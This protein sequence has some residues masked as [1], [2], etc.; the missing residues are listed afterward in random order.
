MLGEAQA[1]HTAGH[2]DDAYRLEE[3]IATAQRGDDEYALFHSH[4]GLA[5]LHYLQQNYT[6]AAARMERAVES[7]S[8][9]KNL[10]AHGVA[11]A[12]EM[13]RLAKNAEGVTKHARLA[14]SAFTGDRA[15]YPRLFFNVAVALR[16]IQ[17]YDE[18]LN[19]YK[20]FVDKSE[21]RLDALQNMAPVHALKGDLR[22][23]ASAMLEYLAS[24]QTDH[25][26]RVILGV[27]LIKSGQMDSAMEHFL[28]VIDSPSAG[29]EMRI[30]AYVN[31]GA[32]HQKRGQ[33]EAA[34]RLYA[35]ALKLDPNNGGAHNNMGSSLW[36]LSDHT[37]AI[38][39]FKR[40]LDVKYH[41]VQAHINLGTSLYVLGDIVGARREYEIAGEQDAK[42]KAAMLLRSATLMSP[43]MKSG[44]YILAERKRVL[45]ELR[46]L[47]RSADEALVIDDPA[48]DIE[49][50][51]F[52]LLYHG[53]NELENQLA[54]R[55]VHAR[56]SHACYT[57][58][59]LTKSWMGRRRVQ[60][61]AAPM[62]VAFVSRSLH[63]NH[64]H[65]QLLQGVM[66][67]LSRRLFDVYAVSFG[68]A[69][70]AFSDDIVR[71]LPSDRRFVFSLDFTEA[72]LQLGR[73]EL[74]AIVYAD[75]MSEPTTHYMGYARLAPVQVAFWGNPVSSGAPHIDY[76][77]SGDIM[78]T[79]SAWTHY[80]NSCALLASGYGMTAACRRRCACPQQNHVTFMVPQSV[81]KFHPLTQQSPKLCNALRRVL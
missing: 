80:S 31:A 69:N 78:E 36:Q 76:F 49:R 39:H 28:R 9:S 75:T 52:Y 35:A 43:I 22:S 68:P 40:S 20:I 62:R 37:Q 23:A 30:R 21:T 32:I 4:R 45:E 48:T 47:S 15:S 3:V 56:M 63:E 64:A 13:M 53:K 66:A 16:D 57:A 44:A 26:A 29:E 60:I 54:V 41:N 7:V 65:G 58:P 34:V 70:G 73:L 38:E 10:L 33:F 27:Y 25:N 5:L 6:A 67:H 11:D 50:L 74:D 71:A 81:F 46:G 42:Y 61:N 51:H 2:H 8:A 79:A 59:H 1:H 55:A 19:I 12:V 72:R 24:N 77:L 18:A 14:L 17:K